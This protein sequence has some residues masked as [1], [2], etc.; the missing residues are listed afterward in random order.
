MND[1][2]LKRCWTRNTMFGLIYALLKQVAAG[3][4]AQLPQ[5]KYE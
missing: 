3:Y 2:V 4:T 1:D 5:Y